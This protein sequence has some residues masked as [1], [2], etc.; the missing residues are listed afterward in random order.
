MGKLP[1]PLG[2]PFR[3]AARDIGNSMAGI[4]ADVA[5]RTGQ[6]QADLNS[7]HGPPVIKVITEAS[8][9]GQISITG[10]GWALG[11]GNIR[12]HAAQGAYIDRGTGP[13]ADDVLVRASKGELI[14]PAHLVRAG[15]ADN[16]RGLIPGFAAGGF[17][18]NLGAMPGAAGV[19]AG[20]D[21]GQAVRTGVAKAMAAAHAVVAAK[22]LAAHPPQ[23]FGPVGS[24]PAR[25]GSVAVEQRYAA[26]LMSQYGWGQ[27][28]MPPLISLWNQES[29]WNP[30]AVNA[31]SG[32]YGIPQSLGHGHPYNLGDY[33]NQIIWGLNYIKGRYGSP[34][35]AWA[36]E[37]ANNW[38]AEGGLI[39]GYASGG[40]AGP[41]SAYLKAWQDKRGGGFGAAWGPVVV[42]QQIA[43][44]AAAQRSAQ[45]LASASG[46]NAKQHA[47]YRAVA[48]GDAKRLAVLNRELAVERTWRGQLGGSDVDPG[49][50]HRRRR[51]RPR[52]GEER[53]RVESADGPA[54]SHHRGHLQDAR[55]LGRAAGRDSEGA[56][57][58]RPDRRA[59]GPHVRRRR[60]RHHRGVPGVGRGA[61]RRGQGRPGLR[62][63]RL[64]EARVERH[65]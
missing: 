52:P 34:S 6:I 49:P 55:L 29:G 59:G 50:G 15:A 30:Y 40:V 25:T 56:P 54:E 47:H 53:R 2:A 24:S 39:P 65:L 62:P 3:T 48:T 45:V 1:G 28:Q 43:A 33:Q 11:Q 21:A 51:E 63:G 38:Y 32:A 44:M 61:V 4:T 37:V 5:R 19:I 20:G 8:G 58:A 26:S 7:I 42:N 57:A 23:P 14:V 64:A 17:P 13:T 16:M 46:L 18:G 12:F 35:A 31:S 22:A 36:H 60:N 41:A 27:N 9:T 10:S